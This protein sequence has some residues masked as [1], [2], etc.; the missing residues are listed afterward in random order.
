[1]QI[2][3]FGG[4]GFIGQKLSE[5]LINL[6]HNVTCISRR[7][8]PSELTTS[9]SQKVHWLRSDV[10][11]DDHWHSAV[12]KADWVIDAIGILKENP[13]KNI[14][15]ERFILE[16]VR[17]ILAYL[18]TQETP[19]KFLFL[20]ANS[21]PF[22]LRKYM[23]AKLQAEQLI[24]EQAEQSVIIYPSL[25]VDKKRFSS[26]ISAFFINLLKKIPGLRKIVQGY[27]PISREVLAH[28]IANV[29]EGK[30]SPYTHR[31]T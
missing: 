15:Y 7:G 14:T 21:A 24:K 18:N 23:D 29:I 4:S 30:P 25:V 16:P 13:S 5:E 28:E 2:T 3:I 6:G 11:T 20:S 8:K 10:L 22:P 31:R 9:W 19:A 27:D 26:V 17:I 1:M 12:Q